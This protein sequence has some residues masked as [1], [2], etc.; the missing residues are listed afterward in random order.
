MVQR[1]PLLLEIFFVKCGAMTENTTQMMADSFLWILQKCKKGGFAVA[2]FPK[3][4]KLPMGV[5]EAVSLVAWKL[6]VFYFG[7]VLALC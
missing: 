3:F 1:M 4:R 5:F 6:S 7:L 2:S